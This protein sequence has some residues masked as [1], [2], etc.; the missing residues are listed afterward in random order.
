VRKFNL[1][2]VA[3]AFLTLSAKAEIRSLEMTVFGMD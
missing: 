3:L 2:I 1:I